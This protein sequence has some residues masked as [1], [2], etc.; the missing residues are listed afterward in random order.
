MTILFEG[1][2]IAKS[3]GKHEVLKGLDL[4]INQGDKIAIIG[5]N[6]SGK[7]TLI[8]IILG[9]V[10]Y[11]S[12]ELNFP[13]HNNKQSDFIKNVGIQFQNSNF[14]GNYTIAQIV[15]IVFEI[16]YN[17]KIKEFQKWKNEIRNI[18]REKLLKLLNLDTKSKYKVKNLS[19]GELQRLNI[20]VSIISNPKILILDEIST[21]LDIKAQ[22]EL[23]NYIKDFI[24][25]NEITLIIISHLIHEIEVLADKIFVLEDG[26]IVLEKEIKK[27]KKGDLRKFI[28]DYFFKDLKK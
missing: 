16:K 8:N 25:E 26:K 10:N 24:E 14:P 9:F 17:T 22:Y 20:L 3:F 18:E 11:D 2:N 23:L 5:A 13:L 15:D 27:N 12:G 21:G 28:D 1:K 7:T 6:G 19:G 4:I